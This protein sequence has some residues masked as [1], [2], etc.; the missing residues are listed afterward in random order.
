MIL[1]W[2]SQGIPCLLETGNLVHTY[3]H[4]AIRTNISCLHRHCTFPPKIFNKIRICYQSSLVLLLY[5][6]VESGG[7]LNH[8]TYGGSIR[9]LKFYAKVSPSFYRKTQEYIRKGYEILTKGTRLREHLDKSSSLMFFCQFKP[10]IIRFS[11][12]FFLTQ[13]YQTQ[14]KNFDPKISYVSA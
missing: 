6:T 12:Y 10:R 8:L 7:T 3:L 2:K 4:R 11:K 13:K 1:I 9:D 14:R 5:L